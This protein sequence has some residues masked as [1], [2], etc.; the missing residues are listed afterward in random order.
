MS[1]K[2][3]VQYYECVVLFDV[4][5]KFRSKD[6]PIKLK[7]RVTNINICV[8]LTIK[9]LNVATRRYIDY[10]NIDLSNVTGK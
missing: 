1:Q 5:V 2:S 3:I 6:L 10:K 9:T 7:K 8:I 4:T